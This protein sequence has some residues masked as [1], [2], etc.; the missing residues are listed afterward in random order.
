M[1]LVEAELIQDEKYPEMYRVYWPDGVV[2][3]MVNITR[4]KDAIRRYEEY[5]RRYPNNRPEEAPSSLT[6]AFK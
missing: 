6:G 4:A 2:S 5:E 3:D 1:K